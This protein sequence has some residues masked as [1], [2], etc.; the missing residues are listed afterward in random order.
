[1]TWKNIKMTWITA[2]FP[3]LPENVKQ[4]LV[5]GTTTREGGVSIPPYASLNLATH[6]EDDMQDVQANRAILRDSLQL[7]S[8][9]YWLNQ[10]HSNIVIE[11]PY[12][13]RSAQNS[14]AISIIE[15]DAAFTARPNHICCVMTADCLPV[16]IVD[17]SGKKV[18]AVHCGW[19]GLANGVLIN[20]LAALEVEG[21]NLHVW[22]GPAIGPEKFEVGAEVKQEFVSL[23]SKN[24]DCFAAQ[25]NGKYLCDIYKL[26][27][28]QLKDFGVV[29]ISGGNYCTV[30]QEDKFFSY[31]RN[32]QTGRMAS[33]IWFN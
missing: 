10:T 12:Q 17:E 22:L 6:V 1:M 31:R 30:K 9:P 16:L 26:A 2:D 7:P 15:A 33:M 5:A 24:S 25:D 14:K 27:R 4:H 11:L 13:Y 23:T 29:H 18:A 28:L 32:G 8:E 3:N 19:R 20:T 21:K